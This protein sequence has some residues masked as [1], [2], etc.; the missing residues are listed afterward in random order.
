MEI[1]GAVFQVP[2][3]RMPPPHSPEAGGS[4]LA[5]PREGLGHGALGSGGPVG[6]S[7]ALAGTAA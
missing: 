7:A 5:Q 1:K 6:M 4:G 3:R 2:M